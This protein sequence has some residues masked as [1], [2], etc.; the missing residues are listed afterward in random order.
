VPTLPG[1]TA[2]NDRHDR[3]FTKGCHKQTAPRYCQHSIRRT[4]TSQALTRWRHN[5]HPIKRACYSFVDL[6]RIKGWVGLVGWPAADGPVA[7]VGRLYALEGSLLKT[8]LLDWSCGAQ[9]H[10]VFA[11]FAPC[12]NF[13]T[14]SVTYSEWTC[15]WLPPQVRLR[16][17]C[18]YPVL[19]NQ[20]G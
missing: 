5:T 6:G 13:L 9:W 2:T 12:I 16:L 18:S 15:W 14:Y 19:V 20:S 3:F 10:F 11:F 8:H 1:W 7:F 17:G 4:F